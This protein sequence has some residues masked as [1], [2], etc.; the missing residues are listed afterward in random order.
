MASK[1][2]VSEYVAEDG[3]NRR[4]ARACNIATY[5]IGNYDEGGHISVKELRREICQILDV[6]PPSTGD[7]KAH[8]DAW[9]ASGLRL[10]FDEFD[11]QKQIEFSLP[12]LKRCASYLLGKGP[13]ISALKLIRRLLT[14]VE[15]INVAIVL[16]Q[17]NMTNWE[18]KFIRDMNCLWRSKV[19][20]S[21][22]RA[23]LMQ[24]IDER[25]KGS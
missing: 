8:G 14:N 4:M 18:K 6:A 22:Q 25:T 21:S 17:N 9:G 11:G 16:S 24:I 20:S 7:L 1:M 19:L 13:K 3:D 10:D 5:F 2:L 15:L 23:K 12:N